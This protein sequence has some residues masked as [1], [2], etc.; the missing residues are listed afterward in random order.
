MEGRTRCPQRE[1]NHVER[2]DDTPFLGRCSIGW[3][4]LALMA[5]KQRS[6]AESAEA[7]VAD[8]STR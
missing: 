8:E 2:R 5:V 1:G 3:W 7:I 4:S 6:S